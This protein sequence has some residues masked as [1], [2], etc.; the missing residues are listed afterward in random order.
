MTQILEKEHKKYVCKNK[1]S[2]KTFENVQET[3][4]QKETAAG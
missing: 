4:N 2:G 1:P 3:G